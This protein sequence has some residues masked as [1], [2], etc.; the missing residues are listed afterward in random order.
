LINGGTLVAQTDFNVGGDWTL[1]SGAFTPGTNTVTFNGTGAFSIT[2]GSSSFY[3][4]NF[5]SGGNLTLNGN[6]STTGGD[7]DFTNVGGIVLG[8]DVAIQ[9]QSGGNPANINLRGK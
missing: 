4:L 8:S 9:A 7:I 2:P 6:L 1:S 5:A 3:A